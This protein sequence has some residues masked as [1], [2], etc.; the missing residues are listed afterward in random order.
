MIAA[1]STDVH[2]AMKSPIDH[3]SEIDATQ[4]RCLVNNLWTLREE[5][6]IPP[7]N[8]IMLGDFGRDP[9][10][11][12]ALGLLASHDIMSPFSEVVGLC[13]IVA[14]IANLIP[15]QLRAR[16]AKQILLHAGLPEIP[17]A[18]GSTAT[19]QTPYFDTDP[20][21]SEFGPKVMKKMVAP[22]GSIHESGQ[23]T[24][25]NVLQTLKSRKEKATILCTT[26][27]RD[28]AEFIDDPTQANL[29]RDSINR[30]V[31]QGGQVFRHGQI[32]P[33]EDATNNAYD[34]DAARKF[35]TFLQVSKIQS[36]SHR[37]SAGRAAP[38]PGFLF[39]ALR[40]VG[41]PTAEHLADRHRASAQSLWQRSCLSPERRVLPRVTGQHVLMTLTNFPPSMWD[42]LVAVEIERSQC[43]RHVD[44]TQNLQDQPAWDLL[45]AMDAIDAT[46]LSRL[47]M[48]RA[49]P[50]LT[51]IRSIAAS[52]SSQQPGPPFTSQD[53]SEADLFY[54]RGRLSGLASTERHISIEGSGIV[55]DRAIAIQVA[56][57]VYSLTVNL[58][59]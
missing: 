52:T 20:N 9:D 21:L 44:I 2:S 51:S 25:L 30:V 29:F 57:I 40:D 43:G 55:P 33:D 47:G 37:N 31:L 50:D 8:I 58:I 35:Y 1:W 26:S 27:L 42:D 54:L 16:H 39:C 53:K 5:S 17:V 22:E 38:L 3:F 15:Q 45:A 19:D 28:L 6:G 36:S 7:T 11:G 46:M 34:V 48:L 14:V 13:R 4:Y 23:M 12:L 10:D 32:R 24:L 41:S 56:A 59:D 49:R 18:S